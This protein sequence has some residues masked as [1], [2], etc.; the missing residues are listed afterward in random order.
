MIALGSPCQYMPANLFEDRTW[1]QRL[2][3]WELQTKWEGKYSEIIRGAVALLD[4][5]IG[6]MQMHCIDIR[7]Y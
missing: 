4:K 1:L 7:G 5:L 6:Y 3:Q 2:K